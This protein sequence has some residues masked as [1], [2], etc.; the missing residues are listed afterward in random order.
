MDTA[1]NKSDFIVTARKWR[2]LKFK[3]VVGQDHITLTLINAIRLNRVH[4][5]FLFSGP[6]GVGKTTTARILARAMNCSNP[7]D[8]EPCNECESCL[9]ILKGNSLDVNEIDGASNNSVEDVRKLRESARYAPSGKY[10]MYIIDEVHMLSTAAFNALLKTLEEPPPHLIFV[11]AT[12]EQHKVPATILS[13]CQRFGFRRLEID[14]I[15]QHLGYIASKEDIII[16]EESL[17]TIAKKADGSMRDAQS[18]FDQVTAFCG[19]NIRYSEMADALHLIDYDFFFRISDAVANG[20]I[21]EMLRITREVTA[22][23]YDLMECMQGILE[24]F[25]N[26]LTVKVTGKTSLIESATTFLEKYESEAKKFNKEDILRLLNLISNA[27]QNLRWASQPK[28]RFETALTQMAAIDSSLQI[29]ELIE[30]IRALK[31][32]PNLILSQES[33]QINSDIQKKKV[34]DD[35]NL[36][37]ILNSK[38]N[39]DDKISDNGKVESVDVLI[40]L[41]DILNISDDNSYKENIASENEITNPVSELE[42]KNG[43]KDFLLNYA[44]SDTGLFM[45]RQANL[46]PVFNNGNILLKVRESSAFNMINSLR[47]SI[48]EFARKHYRG[49]ATVQ[50]VQEN[51]IIAPV[52]EP[53][54]NTKQ[55][56]SRINVSIDNKEFERNTSINKS[57]LSTQELD[58]LLP[59]ERQII[60]LFGAKEVRKAK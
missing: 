26:I 4:H 60:E 47:R 29:S 16:D 53:D 56:N 27:E 18:L 19:S 1:D 13:R 54:E 58:N 20:N 33:T 35:S 7:T 22:K 23:G 2:P 17:V 28:I 57:D 6:R 36:R 37:K 44:N 42:L 21:E 5:A 14:L 8:F 48:E 59:I 49:F 43:W 30:E 34:D 32:N 45:L 55:I 9:S 46:H 12:T 40:G 10:K 11:F 51:V 31:K 24:H 50:I 3:D 39:E 52:E 25:R 41:P 38:S 15:I